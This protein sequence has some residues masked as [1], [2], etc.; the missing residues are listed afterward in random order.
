VNGYSPV[1]RAEVEKV[2]RILV[3]ADVSPQIGVDSANDDLVAIVIEKRPS[4]A[5]A[6]VRSHGS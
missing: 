4:A 5:A 3:P 2:I 1:A 6:A